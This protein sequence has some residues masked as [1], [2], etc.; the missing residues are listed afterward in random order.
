MT[1]A[2]N[3]QWDVFIR[4]VHWLTL[5]LIVAAWWAVETH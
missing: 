4:I 5:V 2:E 3:R 1:T